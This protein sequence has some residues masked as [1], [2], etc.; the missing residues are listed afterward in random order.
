MKKFWVGQATHIDSR[1]GY[2]MFLVFPD[3]LTIDEKNAVV[4]EAR[5]DDWN[6]WEV[7]HPIS[8]ARFE[9][10]ARSIAD[11]SDFADIEDG[12][13]ADLTEPYEYL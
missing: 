6:I 13:L 10:L 12:F 9:A 11:H 2:V 4:A 1:D 8:R 3:D 7:T 5:Q